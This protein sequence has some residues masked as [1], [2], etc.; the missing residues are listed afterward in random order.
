MEKIKA[1]WRIPSLFKGIDPQAAYEEIFGDGEKTL[2]EI[3]DIARDERSA[4]HDYFEWDDEVA[5]EEYRKIQ[6]AKMSRSF[7]LVREDKETGK[8]EKTEFRLVQVDSTRTNTYQPVKFFLQN[9]DEYQL[10]LE[11]AK[12]ELQGFRKRYKTLTELEEIFND[13]DDL[14]AS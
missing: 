1:G 3:V 4:I 7:I 11:R 6:A 2:E 14:L 5:S 8:E 12:N 13:I 9:K 10:L